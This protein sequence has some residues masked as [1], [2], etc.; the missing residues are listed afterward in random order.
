MTSKISWCQETKVPA[1]TNNPEPRFQYIP[2]IQ[3]GTITYSGSICSPSAHG[4][5]QLSFLMVSLVQIVL[6]GSSIHKIIILA[7]IN[8]KAQCKPFA[9]TLYQ[10]CTFVPSY[11]D[12]LWNSE[13]RVCRLYYIYI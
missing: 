8:R 9:P 12:E 4:L 2:N 7:S 5:A 13:T 1:G 6:P 3:I 10:D 11:T